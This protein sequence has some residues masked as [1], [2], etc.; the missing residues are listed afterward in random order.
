MLKWTCCGHS[1]KLHI[2]IL[3]F[4]LLQIN[5]QITNWKLQIHLGIMSHSP[6][7]HL[8]D[9]LWKSDIFVIICGS[10]SP[11]WQCGLFVLALLWR[12]CS[13]RLR[14]RS[15]LQ[16]GEISVA[17]SHLYPQTVFKPKRKHIFA[18]ISSVFIKLLIESH[19]IQIR[20]NK[21]LY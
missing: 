8:F 12:V 4:G 7:L 1:V 21:K 5:S 10:L 17:S 3:C 9:M 19:F 20:F 15:T 18:A 16:G 13:L 6:N 2:S 14:H 11:R